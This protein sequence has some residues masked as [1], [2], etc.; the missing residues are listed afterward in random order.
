MI[1]FSLISFPFTAPFPIYQTLPEFNKD[2]F[3]ESMRNVKK[4]TFHLICNPHDF[5]EKA[6][7]FALNTETPYKIEFRT[8]LTWPDDQF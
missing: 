8:L 6:K 7:N 4:I 2:I 1:Y 3:P 5:I